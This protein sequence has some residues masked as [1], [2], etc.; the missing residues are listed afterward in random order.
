MIGEAIR[1]DPFGLGVVAFRQEQGRSD[2]PYPP[3][4]FE[5]RDWLAGW[6]YSASKAPRPRA[7]RELE[8]APA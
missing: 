8:S 2:C 1:T 5:A 6:D 4:H 7:T 3:H